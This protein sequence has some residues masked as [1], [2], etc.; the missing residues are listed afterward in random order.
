MTTSSL[1]RAAALVALLQFAAH[2]I[3]FVRAKPTH[4]EIEVSVVQT[5]RDHRFDFGRSN[6]SYWDMYFGY[7]LEAAFIC[8][9]E[10]ILFWLLSAAAVGN[11]AVV[12]PIIILFLAANIG[13]AFL[14]MRYFFLVPLIPDLLIAGLLALSL[15]SA[16]PG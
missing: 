15:V 3:M 5:M 9:V 13:H 2:G 14:V 11:P 4:G 7:G 10:A 8:L 12:K 1:L 6:R 16:K